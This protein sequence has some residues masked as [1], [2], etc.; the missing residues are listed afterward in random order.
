MEIKQL[1]Y[2]SIRERM[3]DGNHQKAYLLNINTLKTFI[4]TNKHTKDKPENFVF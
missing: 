4:I 3:K 1:E 2:N